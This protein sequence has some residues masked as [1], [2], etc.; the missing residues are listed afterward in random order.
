MPAVDL[1]EQYQEH[2]SLSHLIP[3]WS[4]QQRDRSGC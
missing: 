1:D 2:T 4:E 3:G